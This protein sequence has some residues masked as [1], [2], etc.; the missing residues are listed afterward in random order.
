MGTGADSNHC[1]P[2]ALRVCSDCWS[3]HYF[4]DTRSSRPRPATGSV[5]RGIQTGIAKIWRLSATEQ[6]CPFRL[7]AAGPQFCGIHQLGQSLTALLQRKNLVIA[8][9]VSAILTISV[10]AY[11]M[12]TYTPQY[13]SSPTTS[14]KRFHRQVVRSCDADSRAARHRSRPLHLAG[15]GHR[16]LGDLRDRDLALMVSRE[17]CCWVAQSEAVVACSQ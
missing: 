12:L 5:G 9:A 16:V 3:N 7:G 10:V 11:S 15:C 1:L 4:L 17:G 6:R 13:T 14:R 2:G 8:S